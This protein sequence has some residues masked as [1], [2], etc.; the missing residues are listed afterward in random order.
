MRLAVTWGWFAA[1]NI[2]V[3]FRA[4]YGKS[5]WLLVVAALLWLGGVVLS[6][7]ELI[8]DDDG[9]TEDP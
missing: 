5:L 3:A 8:P 1:V 6:L 2:C 4:F 9:R 7:T